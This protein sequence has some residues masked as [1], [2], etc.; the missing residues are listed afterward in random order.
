MSRLIDH[1]LRLSRLT[2]NEMSYEPVDLSALARE[3]LA[4]LSH[5][6]PARRVTFDLEDGLTAEGDP[7]LL[8]TALQNLLENAW[9]YTRLA[10]DAH[11]TFSSVQTDDETSYVVSDNGVGFDMAYADKLFAPFER[12]HGVHEFE[13]TGVGLT[14]VNRIVHRHGGLIRGEGAVGQGATFT[15]TLGRPAHD[16]PTPDPLDTP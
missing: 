15:F 3:T 11:I 9:K 6:E 5:Q 2:R 7:I 1:L 10:P 4:E 14:T 8:R 16:S 12:L 13:G